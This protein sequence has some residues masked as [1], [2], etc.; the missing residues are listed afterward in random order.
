MQKRQFI[1]TQ[2]G[3]TQEQMALFLGISRAHYAMYETNRRTIPDEASR[4]LSELAVVIS[5]SPEGKSSRDSIQKTESDR[6]ELQSLLKEND[7]QYKRAERALAA[8]ISKQQAV[9]KRGWLQHVL[10]KASLKKNGVPV[11]IT[12]ILGKTPS[13][14]VKAKSTGLLKLQ[15][16]L[17]V[18]G[19]ERTVLERKLSD[20][21]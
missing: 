2:L 4:L 1:R 19:L 16:R 8:V 7:Y 6:Q 20:L 9:E 12:T 21:R 18:L 3:L 11:R 5:N 10:G 13:S 15:V 17:E 14:A